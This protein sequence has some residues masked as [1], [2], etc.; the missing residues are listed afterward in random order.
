MVKSLLN[1]FVCYYIGHLL[2]FEAFRFFAVLFY[3]FDCSGVC[4]KI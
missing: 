1:I 4:C 3:N 2:V